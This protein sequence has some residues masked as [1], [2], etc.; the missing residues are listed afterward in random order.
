M[1]CQ[2]RR[3]PNQLPQ[4]L[5]LHKRL[6]LRP[7]LRLILELPGNPK[8][9]IT[10]FFDILGKQVEKMH[11]WT[12][13][14]L[15]LH[16]LLRIIASLLVDRK[17]VCFKHVLKFKITSCSAT[18]A[19]YAA[20]SGTNTTRPAAPNTAPVTHTQPSYASA[21]APIQHQRSSVGNP[22]TAI[23]PLTM[24]NATT[25]QTGSIQSSVGTPVESVISSQSAS[26]VS[27]MSA[28]VNSPLNASVTPSYA[29]V[30][31]SGSNITPPPSSSGARTIW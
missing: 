11:Q 14:L 20:V 19:S 12:R 22:P 6:Q 10:L 8:W 24:P 13:L 23:A 21:A 18:Q 29:N 2:R 27:P 26:V 17:S 15:K 25:S 16:H 30:V 1:K 28:G 31:A 3:D 7:L 4:T 5:Q 9:L